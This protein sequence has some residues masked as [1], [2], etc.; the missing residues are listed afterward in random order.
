M[1]IDIK[2]PLMKPL[3]PDLSLIE[4]YLKTIDENRWYSNFGPLVLS[5][6]ERMAEF[7]GVTSGGVVSLSSGTA[8][9]VNTLRAFNLPTDSC[10][11]VP[12]WTFVATAAAPIAAGLKPYFLDVDKESWSLTPEIAIEALDNI[13]EQVSAAIVTSP[14]GAP[15]VT[16]AW[17]QFTKDTGVQVIIDAAAGFYSFSTIKDSKPTNTPVMISLHATKLCGCGE[18][19]L[20]ISQNPTLIRKIKEI[21]NFGF[22]G[23]REIR[24]PG[25]NGKMSEYSAAVGHTALDHWAEKRKQWIDLRHKYLERLSNIGNGIKNIWISDD[26][27]AATCNIRLNNENVDEVMDR[28]NEKGIESRQWWDKGCH[29]QPA[30][31]SYPRTDLPVTEA[32]AESVLALPFSIDLSEEEID[33]ITSTLSEILGSAQERKAV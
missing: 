21:S 7:F 15:V 29:K 6:E 22:S 2:I 14:F 23:S 31:A 25:T 26:W 30:Y 32:L 3:L 11:L 8:G 1:P 27:A 10:C 24:I 12:S 9:L 16:K 13:D 17:D 20:V 4:P 5:L 18:G 28:L 33:Y 19:G